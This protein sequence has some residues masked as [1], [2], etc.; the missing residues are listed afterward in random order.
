MDFI[1]AIAVFVVL[2]F[3]EI[4]VPVINAPAIMCACC[5]SNIKATKCWW[6]WALPHILCAFARIPTLSRFK[7]AEADDNH[8]HQF[9]GTSIT[10][11]VFY[12]IA[13]ARSTIY[14]LNFVLNAQDCGNCHL[15]SISMQVLHSSKFIRNATVI[16][17][18]HGKIHGKHPH[19]SYR[20]RRQCSPS[21][22]STRNVSVHPK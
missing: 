8:E 19:L 17:A 2:L 11:G 20:Y 12:S 4:W 6:W 18:Q 21:F 22:S 1:W 7:F 16:T 15:Y 9:D 3:W 10:F 14:S 13:S 5:D